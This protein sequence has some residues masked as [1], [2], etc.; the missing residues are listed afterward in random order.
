MEL[1]ACLGCT[2]VWRRKTT[3][4]LIARPGEA[5]RNVALTSKIIDLRMFLQSESEILD[6]G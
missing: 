1:A 2:R 3:A 6:E 5:A 4:S